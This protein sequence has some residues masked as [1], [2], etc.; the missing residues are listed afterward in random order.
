LVKELIY[1]IDS[2]T[3]VDTLID[4]LEEKIE[5]KK[6]SFDEALGYYLRD[7]KSSFEIHIL[8]KKGEFFELNFRLKNIENE[9]FVKEIFGIPQKEYVKD[10][11]ILDVAEFIAKLNL[12]KS[13]NEIYDLVKTHFNL[14]KTKYDSFIKLIIKQGSRFNARK[15]L[16]DAAKRLR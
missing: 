7:N 8:P 15:Y 3:H 14:S 16:K 9:L 11:S 1:S 13:E 10:A 2:K 6:A 4:R 5:L 12:D